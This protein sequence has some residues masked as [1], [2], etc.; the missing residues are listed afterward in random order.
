M[1][2][3]VRSTNSWSSILSSETPLNNS[4]SSNNSAKSS[5]SSKSVSESSYSASIY[6]S[7]RFHNKSRSKSPDLMAAKVRSTNS[8]ISVLS[9][10]IT[11]NNSRFSNNSARSSS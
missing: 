7:V 9:F 11:F 6:A 4:R 2:A 1:A 8:L 10:E 3:K 5:S